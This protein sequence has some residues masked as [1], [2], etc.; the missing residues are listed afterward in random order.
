MKKCSAIDLDDLLYSLIRK[1][2]AAG[3]VRIN[4]LICPE[5]DRPDDSQTEDIVFNTV[6]VTQDKP[7]DGTSNINIYVPD[8][9]VMIRGKE[10]RSAN[11]ER[12]KQIGDALVS[13]IDAQNLPDLELWTESDTI[14]SEPSAGQHYRNIRV[15]WNIN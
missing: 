3:V 1:A 6:A 2:A 8:H 4:G 9:R 12:L 13:F 14:L 15:K 11:R 10:Q 5:G 7:Q